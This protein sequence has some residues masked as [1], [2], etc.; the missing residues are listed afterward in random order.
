MIP[1]PDNKLPS[2]RIRTSEILVPLELQ[3][4]MN[5]N[6]ISSKEFSEILG[7]SEQAVKLWL[8]GERKF[9]VTN[10][11]LVKLFMK[12]ETLIKEF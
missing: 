11:R 2:Q 10:S 8:T 3:A 9:S 4:F 1:S 7:V 5:D 6:G 12:Y